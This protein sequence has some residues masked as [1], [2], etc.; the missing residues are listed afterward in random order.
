MRKN[1]FVIL[2]GMMLLGF[3]IY[4]IS[5]MIYNI[6]SLS[7]YDMTVDWNYTDTLFI[8]WWVLAPLV[9]LGLGGYMRSIE[10]KKRDIPRQITQQVSQVI[11]NLKF[12]PNC[13]H[14]N[15][16]EAKFCVTCGEKFQA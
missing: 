12:C 4:V 2:F 14:Q 9:V 16:V 11:G 15:P 10:K 6:S 1:E 3:S 7:Y 5:Y 8:L 13:G